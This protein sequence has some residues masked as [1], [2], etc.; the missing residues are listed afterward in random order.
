MRSQS[1]PICRSAAVGY[2]S[3]PPEPMAELVAVRA[4]FPLGTTDAAVVALAERLG[5]TEIATPLTGAISTRFAP[6]YPRHTR[7]LHPAALI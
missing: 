3:Q 7:R 5:I 2:A 4:D 1:R 6:P